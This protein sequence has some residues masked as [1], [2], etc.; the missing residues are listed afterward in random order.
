MAAALLIAI[1]NG[2]HVPPV[3]WVMFGIEVLLKFL[4]WWQDD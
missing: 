2:L 3:I 4:E 1:Y